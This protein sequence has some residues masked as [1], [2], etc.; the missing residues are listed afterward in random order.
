MSRRSASSSGNGTVYVKGYT[1]ANGTYVA[2]YT[3]SAPGASRSSSSHSTA[4]SSSGSAVHVSGYTRANGTYVEGYTRASPGAS[5]SRS[6]ASSAAAAEDSLSSGS[7]VHVRGYTRA[8]GTYVEGYTR[9]SPGASRSRSS[10]SSASAVE[11]SLSSRSVVHVRGYTRDNGTYVEGYTRASPGASRSRSSTSSA[12]A[13][14]DSLSSR[15]IV[16]VRGYT[17]ANGTYVEGYTRASPG[18]SRSRSSASSAAAAEDS[19]SS[20]SVVHV[21]G[22]TRANGTYVEGYTRAS[23]G[24]LRSRSS[25][26]SAAAAEDSLSS[27]S[28]V[29]VRGYTRANGTYV[30]GYTRTSPGASRSR[31]STSSATAVEKSSGGSIRSSLKA[32]GQRCYVDNAYNRSVGRVGKPIGTCIISRKNS[33][34]ESGKGQ[35]KGRHRTCEILEEQTHDDLVRMLED[36]NFRGSSR[37]DH[38]YALDRLRREEVEETWRR[39]PPQPASYHTDCRSPPKP[40]SQS[41]P[42][43]TSQHTDHKIIPYA[44]LHLDKRP[45]GRGTFGEVMAGLWHGRKVAFK[46]LL[47]QQMAKQ[48]LASFKTEVT[49]LAT[50]CHPNIVRMYGAV[51]EEGICGIVMEYFPRSLFRSIFIDEYEFSDKTKMLIIVQVANAL[52]YLHTC[53]C[54]IAHGDV[55]SENIL[56]DKYDNVKLVDFGLS[57][58]KN[59][60]ETSRSRAPAAGVTP[61]QGTPR[62]SA[63]EVLKGEM[64][65]LKQLT[66]ADIYSMAI[67]AFE[68]VAEEE[69]FEG[70]SI[71]QLEVNVGRGGLRPESSTALPKAVVD[72]LS[73]SWSDTAS[74]RPTAAQFAT[75]WSGIL[76]SI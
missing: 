28:V 47:Y 31:S 37:T 42:K 69:P 54:M 75:E 11:D 73:K 6:S 4:S 32:S 21:R 25:A 59:A 74:E 22:Y 30:E 76:A 3:R 23:P 58:I 20:G 61:G 7:V 27:G 71:R 9:A 41:P 18:A 39:K 15:S 49:V 68:V 44:E 56:L 53:K 5:R 45:I 66:Q 38:Q 14:E 13:V 17:R 62:Y 55:K 40:T 12:S 43:P 8:N 2:G 36:M 29:H 65:T 10:T 64:L 70:L 51:V 34:K 57:S 16:H 33:K 60:T 72:I 48:R 67:V 26:S 35:S 46:K 1:R 52:H 63:P 19:L 24:A 50:L